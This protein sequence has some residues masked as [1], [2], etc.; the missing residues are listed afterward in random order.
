MADGKW[1]DGLTADAPLLAAAKRALEVRLHVVQ[2]WLPRAVRDADRDPEH[3]H[4]LRV[5]ARRADAALRIFAPCLPRK[6]Y[7]TARAHLRRLRRAAGA[8]RDWDVFLLD[9]A[10][11]RVG[12]PEKQRAGGDFLL[13]YAFA[14]R[15]AAQTELAAAAEEEHAGLERLAAE[16]TADLRTPDDAPHHATLLDLARPVLAARLHELSWTADGDLNEYTHLH[17]VRIAGKRL[18]YAMEIFADC[19]PAPFRERLYPR[20]EDMQEILGRANDSQVASVR[21]ASLRERVRRSTPEEWKRLR[22]GVEVLLRFH[23][24][25]LPL[26]RKRFLAWL[27]AWRKAGGPALAA[28]LGQRVDRHA[29]L[30]EAGSRAS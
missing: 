6:A 1:I 13:G 30:A 18:R 7:K 5:G 11:R 16:T 3:V 28:Y 29:P 15:L 2:H 25:R 23:Q 21:L 26:E 17:E 9:L 14:N 20:I 12:Q 8:A 10:S 24:R 27:E 4:Q 19:F 22:A